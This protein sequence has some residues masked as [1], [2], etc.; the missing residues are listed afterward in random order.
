MPNKRPMGHIAHLRNYFLVINTLDF[1]RM[2]VKR[3]NKIAPPPFFWK[4][5][6]Y[7]YALIHAW[8]EMSWWFWRR[9]FLK[10]VKIYY[11]C[12]SLE[13]G[14]VLCLKILEFPLS[15]DA[16]EKIFFFSWITSRK[17]VHANCTH[18]HTLVQTDIDRRTDRQTDGRTD[19]QTPELN[20]QFRW[21]CRAQF[22]FHAYFKHLCL[23]KL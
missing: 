8:F 18:K 12:I 13:I 23:I 16:L 19:G 10:I 15:K 4:M 1:T 2:L 7:L 17:Y 22:V 9:K 5:I 14:M 20:F 3:K 21:T 6:V 11:T